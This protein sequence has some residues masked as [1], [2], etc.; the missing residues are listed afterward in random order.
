MKKSVIIVHGIGDNSEGLISKKWV[1][2]CINKIE[3]HLNQKEVQKLNSFANNPLGEPFPVNDG[4]I[5]IV[6]PRWEKVP[7]VK[8]KLPIQSIFYVIPLL[9]FNLISL[10]TSYGKGVDLLADDSR[11]SPSDTRAKFST[12]WV[13]S[14]PFLILTGL[15]L[16]LVMI[17][18]I[19]LIKSESFFIS[20]SLISVFLFS[21]LAFTVIKVY[22]LLLQIKSAAVSNEGLLLAKPVI[23]EIKEAIHRSDKILVIGHSQGAYLGYR[24]IQEIMAGGGFEGHGKDIDFISVGSGIQ[25]IFFIN[26]LSGNKKLLTF[27]NIYPIVIIGLILMQIKSFP[28]FSLLPNG[29]ILEGSVWENIGNI[30]GETISFSN[31]LWIFASVVINVLL[32]LW[33]KKDLQSIEIEPLP[34]NSWI[35]INTPNDPVSRSEFP[36]LPDDVNRFPAQV[37]GQWIKDHMFSYYLLKSSDLMFHSSLVW[38]DLLRPGYK[39][40]FIKC[41]RKALPDKDFSIF[42]L[43]KTAKSGFCGALVVSFFIIVG[44]LISFEIG[45]EQMKNSIIFSTLPLIVVAIWNLIDYRKFFNENCNYNSDSLIDYKGKISFH[46]VL[47]P[48]SFFSAA[49]TFGIL[50]SFLSIISFFFNM[51]TIVLIINGVGT[52]V[53]GNYYRKKVFGRAWL[54]IF[55]PLILEAIQFFAFFNIYFTASLNFFGEF[56]FIFLMFLKVLQIATYLYYLHYFKKYNSEI[57]RF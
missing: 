23:D 40:S 54:V 6:E 2:A 51:L 3:V 4:Y 12:A 17:Y 37:S 50:F 29:F 49:L 38:I 39:N 24:S 41:S 14:S 33:A 57:L 8:K 25:P 15:S 55:P 19:L 16:F 34:I 43:Y 13:I 26:R 44:S 47:L 27:F 36:P 5:Q 53:G 46:F 28:K 30:L 31:F 18:P 22:P 45:V 42:Y 1:K 9:F 20:T 10:I 21:L 32:I 35:D 52:I 11:R 56:I 48:V 7:E